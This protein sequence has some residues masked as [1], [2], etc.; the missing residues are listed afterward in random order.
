MTGQILWGAL[1]VV[2]AE[3]PDISVDPCTALPAGLTVHLS[4]T[5]VIA[6]LGHVTVA[7]SEIRQV[8]TA[9]NETHVVV[10]VLASRTKRCA[11]PC[12]ED[13]PLAPLRH[14]SV[15]APLIVQSV[16]GIFWNITVQYRLDPAGIE[17]IEPCHVV[18]IDAGAVAPRLDGQQS[19]FTTFF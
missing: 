5:T 12:L 17:H 1:W 18:D 10:D 2:G 7:S 6:V 14:I 13:A 4:K 8:A 15:T 3:V 9:A 11:V 16:T 19:R